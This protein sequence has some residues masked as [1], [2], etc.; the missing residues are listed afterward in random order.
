MLY[1]SENNI[2]NNLHIKEITEREELVL[3]SIIQNYILTAN[4][5]G[6]NFLATKFEEES[7][8]PATLRNVMASLEDKGFISHPHT[9]AG[10][11]PTD[12]GYRFYVNKF[13][14]YEKL[15]KDEENSIKKNI[16]IASLNNS[17]LQEASNLI[18]KISNQ[19][20]IVTSPEL[21]N[22]LLERI[23]II[24]LSSNKVLIVLSLDGFVRTIT[25]EVKSFIERSD[26]D[27]IINLLNEKL[28]GLTLFRIRNTCH[29]RLKDFVTDNYNC[30][31]KELLNKSNIIFSNNIDS[32]RLHL[33]T[34]HNIMSQP[35]F[36]S[37]EQL[38]GIIEL[39]ENKEVVIHL[40]EN[41]RSDNEIEV[42]IGD[43]NEDKRLQNYSIITKKYNARSALGTIGLIGP[44]RMNYSRMISIIDL[45]SKT[46]STQTIH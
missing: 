31:I 41:S 43:E 7:L 42:T 24:I 17:I 6:S 21:L 26:L 1:Q 36:S 35:D 46:V 18:G 10:R 3:R 33:S 23:E 16:S 37:I 30:L 2:I 12:L 14:K 25:I 34:T 38:R 15:N 19:L 40:L 32:E 20:G 27:K 8:S 22:S 4:P 5:V 11:V 28:S 29:D 9:S 44:K 45:I 39:V 13:L